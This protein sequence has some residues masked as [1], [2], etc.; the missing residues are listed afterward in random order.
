MEGLKFRW[1]Y[2]DGTRPADQVLES[3]V[4]H[5][6][7][8]KGAFIVRDEGAP[9][10]AVYRLFPDVA[11]FWQWYEPLEQK[12][13]H[14]VV[15]GYMPQRFKFD[16]D[17]APADLRGAGLT[18]A[19]VLDAIA[20]MVIDVFV[21]RYQVSLARDD[22]TVF[23]SCGKD[24]T[25]YHLLVTEYMAA[26]N[27]EAKSFTAQVLEELAV[28]A[29][30]VVKFLDPG[31]NKSTQNFRVPGSRKRDSARV[32][33]AVGAGSAQLLVTHPAASRVLGC[34][35]DAKA[36]PLPDICE[37]DVQAGMALVREAGLHHA[38]VFDKSVGALMTFRRTRPSHCAI[39]DR[40]H[41]KDNTLMVM[42]RPS[43]DGD[44]QF[45]E[46]CRRAPKKSR[47]L[48]SAVFC[49]EGNGLER[50]VKAIL[51][52]EYNPCASEDALFDT[53]PAGQKT[54]YSADH[55]REYERVPTLAVKAQM[56]CGKTRALRAYLSAHYPTACGDTARVKPV[57]RFLTFRKTFSDHVKQMFPEFAIYSDSTGVITEPMAIVQIESLH[58]LAAPVGFAAEEPADLVIMDE[59]ESILEQFGSGLHSNLSKSFAIFQWLMHT[60]RHV[61][62]MDANLSDRTFRTLRQLRAHA[63]AHLHWNRVQKAKDETCR[64]TTAPGEWYH[65]LNASL[66][67]GRRVVVATNSLRE[68]QG[69]RDLVCAKYPALRCNLYS[70]KTLQSEKE[71]HLSDVHKHWGALDVLIYTPT[72]SAGVSFELAHFD[73]LFCYFSDRSCGVEVCRQMMARVRNLCLRRQTVCIKALRRSYPTSPRQIEAKLMRSRGM[74]V[75]SATSGCQYEFD[76]ATGAVRPYVSPYFHLWVE[77]RRMENLSRNDFARRFVDQV[78]ATGARVEMLTFEEAELGI[79]ESAMDRR[80]ILQALDEKE[81]REIANAEELEPEELFV[82]REARREQRDVTLGEQ[83]S[84][85][86]AS[87]RDLYRWNGPI[88]SDFVG[89][90]NSPKVKAWFR[91]LCQITSRETVE[92][93]LNDIAQREFVR[94]TDSNPLSGA[95]DTSVQESL[96]LQQPYVHNKHRLAIWLIELCG[97]LSINDTRWLTAVHILTR[98]SF[99]L[100]VLERLIP[101]IETEFDVRGCKKLVAA[102]GKDPQLREKNALRIINGVLRGFY[103]ME[104]K[105]DRSGN[106]VL[107]PVKDARVFWK[108]DRPAI[109][110]KLKKIC[111]DPSKDNTNFIL[112]AAYDDLL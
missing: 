52:G 34:G 50:R 6:D 31:V 13:V 81:R 51:A 101:G 22:I 88:T 74:L 29:P 95:K 76:P 48:S 11:S 64:I 72:I 18:G 71:A 30:A 109:P 86:K 60:A 47:L 3:S 63:P 16:I 99:A 94:F 85:Q 92:L 21:L 84:L 83:L 65:E 57:I 1:L 58:R 49:G 2:Q 12:H 40:K 42:C 78:A 93:A 8:V 28:S 56:K 103:G 100:P 35:A 41:D 80:A 25:S 82:L 110:S 55:M 105:L 10:G 70:S 75:A 17:A 91:N 24:K 61:I 77:N 23:E 54:I 32:K 68:A 108:P 19:E 7:I 67:A 90:L 107:V 39:C 62:C 44:M 26:D 79:K 69:V 45:V 106:A 9:T 89:A 5:D 53:L 20:E 111:E 97:F 96:D 66:A 36:A 33:R 87:L 37:S 112:R 15:F 73:E 46:L 104:V 14:E 27:E 38:H 98:L 43:N 102:T 4:T 59:V